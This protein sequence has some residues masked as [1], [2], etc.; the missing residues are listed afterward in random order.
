MTAIR[1]LNG[2]DMVARTGMNALG[3]ADPNRGEILIREGL[4]KDV[5]MKVRQHEWNHINSGEEG[6]YSWSDFEDDVSDVGKEFVS[7]STLGLGKAVDEVGPYITGEKYA[8]EA[9]EAQEDAANKNLALQRELAREQARQ[10]DLMRSDY[11]PFREAGV[12]QL[13]MLQRMAQNDPNFSLD[14]FQAS[15]G[16]NF[17]LEQGLNALQ[18]SAAAGGSL[19]SGRTL[20]A[21]QEYG[22]GLA[23]QEYG[24]W[25]NQQALD[26]GNKFNRLASLAGIGQTS[27]GQMANLGQNQLAMQQQ[28]AQNVMNMNNQLAQS[29]SAAAMQPYNSM[30]NLVGQGMALWG[31][32]S[33][34]RVKEDIEDSELGLE[35]IKALRPVRWKYKGQ[36]GTH[37]G[38]IAQELKEAMEKAGIDGEMHV[39]GDLEAINYRELIGP[40]IKAVQELSVKVEANG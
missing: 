1:Y 16:Y 6:P 35:F 18:N 5:E 13:P 21:L 33:D 2:R 3:Y 36:E 12:S 39:D 28:G 24:N 31:A 37:D 34:E 17:Q 14:Q 25:R 7:M 38:L 26:Y 40:L 10:F 23:N 9:L 30:T 32:M 19:E 4:P 27:T 11:A 29:Q 8:E 15:P 20:K 22:Q